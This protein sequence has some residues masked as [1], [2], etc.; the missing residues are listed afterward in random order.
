MGL[1]DALGDL[2]GAAVK[3]VKTPVN[4]VTDVAGITEGETKKDIKKIGEDLSD[5]PEDLFEG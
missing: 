1:F 4:I 2:A 3:V 5:I